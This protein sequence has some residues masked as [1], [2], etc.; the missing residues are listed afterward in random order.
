[1][2]TERALFL[3]GPA[4][5]KQIAVNRAYQHYEVA[6]RELVPFASSMSEFIGERTV[7]TVVYER[8]VMHLNGR[9]ISVFF[10]EMSSDIE[11]SKLA[12]DWLADLAA[13]N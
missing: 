12:D 1:M 9:L 10:P 11:R 2:A 13:L 7:K 6:E 5:R 4:Y 3:G 8:K